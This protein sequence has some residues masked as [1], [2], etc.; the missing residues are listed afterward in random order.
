MF[1]NSF[2]SCLVIFSYILQNTYIKFSTCGIYLW[3]RTNVVG[4]KDIVHA[5]YSQPFVSIT[6][7]I[8]AAP[9]RL[10]FTSDRG[11]I[12][13]EGSGID[14]I[15]RANDPP[16]VYNIILMRICF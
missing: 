11:L 9:C 10:K 14:S 2:A 5:P 8:T 13:A 4:H 16:H 3:L 6:S 1:V 15:M 12:G 7:R